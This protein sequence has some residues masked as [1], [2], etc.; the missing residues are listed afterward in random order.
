LVRDSTLK[1]WPIIKQGPV[2]RVCNIKRSIGLL[3]HSTVASVF[4]HLEGIGIV[5]HEYEKM[6][7]VVSTAVPL[8]AGARSLSG[9]RPQMAQ[10]GFSVGAAQEYA[11]RL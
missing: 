11:K 5:R 2:L 3:I 7:S 8:W 6:P 10:D 1:E 4:L 9:P